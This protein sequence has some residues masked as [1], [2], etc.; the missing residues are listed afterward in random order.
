MPKFSAEI[1]NG[2][3]IL[4][5]LRMGKVVPFGQ[6][7]SIERGESCMK[8]GLKNNGKQKHSHTYGHL[9]G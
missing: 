2:D 8:C 9:I 7:S 3:P 5:F 4:L 1:G 6:H